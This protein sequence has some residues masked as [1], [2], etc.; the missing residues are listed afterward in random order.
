MIAE[1]AQQIVALAQRAL[2]L[3]EAALDAVP[4]PLDARERLALLQ[5]PQEAEEQ[6]AAEGCVEQGHFLTLRSR[7]T[8]ARS[9][10]R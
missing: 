6:R 8:P 10:R 4:R 5:E 3:V 7:L 2:G 1:R 9:M